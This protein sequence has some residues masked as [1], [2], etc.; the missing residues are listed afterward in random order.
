V[1]TSVLN[2]VEQNLLTEL[3]MKENKHL[4]QTVYRMYRGY[5]TI[6]LYNQPK[7]YILDNN[8][9]GP[10]RKTN[11]PVGSKVNPGGQV[12]VKDPS[13]LTHVPP[14]LHTPTF[15]SHSFTSVHVFPSTYTKK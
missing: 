1:Q 10:L 4:T 9:Y 5:L 3:L 11:L 12:H 7:S 2:A 6:L 14:P 13:V 8:I 15:R